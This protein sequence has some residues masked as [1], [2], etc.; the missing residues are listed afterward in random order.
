VIAVLVM[1]GAAMA[2][3]W[4]Y[5]NQNPEWWKWAKGEFDKAVAEL[6]LQPEEEP[7]GLTASGFIEAEEAFVTTE[8]GGRVV[9]LYA[10][11]GDRVDKGE[12]LVELDDSLLKAQIEMAKADL[13]VAEALLDQI[14]AGVRHETTA[15][16]RALVKQA[17]VA[18]RSAQIAWQDAEAMRDSPQE[19]ELALTAARAQL[20]VLD[21][22]VRQAQALANSA[23][24]GRDL[25]DEMM[26]LLEDFEPFTVEYEVAPGISYEKEI[27]KLPGDVLP[28]AKHQQATATYQSWEAWSGLEQAQ[29]ALAGS[30]AYIASIQQQ[31]ANPLAL[32]AQANAAQSEYEVATAAVAVAQA[33]MDG[34]QIGATPEQIAAVE[35]QV[36]IARAALQALEVQS[37]ELTLEAPIGGLVLARPIQLGEVALPGVPLLTLADLDHVTLTIYVPEDRLGKV[38]FGQTVSVTVDAYPD[39]AF[40][41]TVTFMATEAEFTPKNVQTREERVNMVFA[42][43][44]ALPNADH[45]LKPGMPADAVLSD[46]D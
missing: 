23:Q 33:Y 39:R 2:A 21:Q 9:K 18:Q 43:K 19:L 45:A 17:E 32:E 20:G 3:G 34:L 14:Q 42:V 8:L 6:G 22:Q 24:V 4:W 5:V 37:D 26:R 44:V 11:E 41:G 40:A 36:E 15:H 1:I 28:E 7:A 12:L 25:A 30:E 38:Q 16:A 46:V 31:L 13:A 35:A 27:K 29:E 10:D